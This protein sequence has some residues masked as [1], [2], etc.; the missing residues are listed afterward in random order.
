MDLTLPEIE[1][2]D[3]VAARYGRWLSFHDAEI[4]DVHLHRDGQSSITIR[5]M[6]PAAHDQSIRFVFERILDLSLHGEDVNRQNVI[7]ALSIENVG[8]ATKVEFSP[9]YG[10]AGHIT[11]EHVS[12]QIE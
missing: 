2:A 4:T 8:Q 7:G 11:A 3:V 10:L 5:V 9:C 6:D 1:G 12:V